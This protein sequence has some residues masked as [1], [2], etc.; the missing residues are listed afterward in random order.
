MKR[1]RILL[2]TVVLFFCG[3]A[4]TVVTRSQIAGQPSPKTQSL[5]AEWLHLDAESAEAINAYDPGF[6]KDLA[7]LRGELAEARNDLIAMFEN[8]NTRDEE[9]RKQIES[10]IEA[11]NQL[12]RRVSNYLVGVRSHLT[13]AQQQRLFSLCADNMRYCWRWQKWRSDGGANSPHS[14]PCGAGQHGGL[15][16]KT[17]GTECCRRAQGKECCQQKKADHNPED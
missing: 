14:E 17:D 12:E 3:L 8:V 11:H 16:G 1:R 9:L 7:R 6:T 13:S 4:G 5:L 10:V 15:D 2:W